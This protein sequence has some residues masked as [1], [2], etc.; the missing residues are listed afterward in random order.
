MA[1]VSMGVAGPVQKCR[2]PEMITG[3]TLR[4]KQLAKAFHEMVGEFWGKGQH[5]LRLLCQ[6]YN[7]ALVSLLPRPL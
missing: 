6:F 4:T 3:S 7:C 5:L 1:I 2:H